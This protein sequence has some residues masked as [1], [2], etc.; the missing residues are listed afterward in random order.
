MMGIFISKELL[1]A[2]IGNGKHRVVEP[3]VYCSDKIGVIVVPAGFITDFA[4]VPRLP[5]VY[6]LFGGVGDEAAVLRDLLYAYPHQ[7]HGGCGIPLTRA[8]VDHILRSAVYATYYRPNSDIDGANYTLGN[9]L[10]YFRAMSMWV[11]VRL[12][13]RRRWKNQ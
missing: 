2:N 3:F 4:S 12:F 7:P 10:A 9:M 6:T 11:G 13:G 8:Q 5:F 1:T